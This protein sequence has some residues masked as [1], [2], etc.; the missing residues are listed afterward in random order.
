ME[1]R[2]SRDFSRVRVHTGEKAAKSARALGARAY[3]VGQNVVFALG[4]YRPA[5][6][7]GRRLLA[8]ELT[9]TLQQ[10]DAV[11]TPSSRVTVA[12]ETD[13][14]R[15]AD[16]AAS[17]ISARAVSAIP[18]LSKLYVPTVQCTGG[19]EGER[20]RIERYLETIRTTDRI[21]DHLDSDDVAREIVATP[22]VY[23]TLTLREKAL[24]VL[25]MLEGFTGD[26]DERAILTI[27]RDVQSQGQLQDLLIWVPIQRLRSNLHGEE[28]RQLETILGREGVLIRYEDCPVGWR[29]MIL[30]AITV[31]QTWISTALSKLRAILANPALPDARTHQALRDH[32]HV[33]VASTGPHV[34][35][36]VRAVHQGFRQVQSAFSRDVPFECETTCDPT[37]HGYVYTGLFGLIRTYTDVHLCPGWS[38][39]TDANARTVTVIHEMAH[40]YAGKDDKAYEWETSKYAGLSTAD[41]L[42]NAECYGAFARD[43][44]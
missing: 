37:V 19:S 15:A 44:R 2:F 14:E 24:L 21:E 4:E 31:A 26:E 5:T 38:S 12:R 40:K 10:R 7:S 25:E 27:L 33:G 11:I 32:F 20:S 18:R 41:A 43:V 9:H 17:S 28:Y 42:N 36:E 34:F 30:R 23:A 13:H 8:H 6:D 16:T 39:N 1:S 35:G 22:E 29:R 3:T